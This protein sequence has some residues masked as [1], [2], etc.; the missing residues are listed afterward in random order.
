MGKQCAACGSR[1]QSL[2]SPGRQPSRAGGWGS[3]AMLAAPGRALAASM[4][5]K[6]RQ[7]RGHHLQS[8]RHQANGLHGPRRAPAKG[9]QKVCP[10]M[11]SWAV[12]QLD[13]HAPGVCWQRPAEACHLQ[14]GTQSSGVQHRLYIPPPCRDAHPAR[15]L[16]GCSAAWPA[17]ARCVQAGKPLLQTGREGH[18]GAAASHLMIFSKVDSTMHDASCLL[19]LGCS[20]APRD[21]CAC[22]HL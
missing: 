11:E 8:L 14:T 1:W 2:H 17:C 20:R 19:E 12:Q 5:H 4:A 13:Q 22:V 18:L 9:S 7:M 6:G 16:T 15:S 21:G 3:Q 10:G